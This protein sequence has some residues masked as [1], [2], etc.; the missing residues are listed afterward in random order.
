[1]HNKGLLLQNGTQRQ[2]AEEL[3]DALVQR[4]LAVLDH[5]FLEEAIRA[6]HD[7]VLVVPAIQ[8]NV[9]GVADLEREQQREALD[10][11]VAAINKVAV[12][13]HRVLFARPAYELKHLEQIIEVPVQIADHTRLGP[14]R[15]EGGAAPARRVVDAVRRQSC[16]PFRAQPRA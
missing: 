5:H 7:A 14:R 10:S 8:V 13:N 2:M 15:N 4:G 11:A 6:T 9:H 1:M 3:A 12:E 16:A